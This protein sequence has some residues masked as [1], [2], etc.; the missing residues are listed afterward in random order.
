M[1]SFLGDSNFQAE[2]NSMKKALLIFF[3][4]LVIAIGIFAAVVA[5]QPDEFRVARSAEINAPPAAVFPHVNDFHNWEKW[6]PWVKLDPNAKYCYEGNPAGEGAIHRWA[7]NEDVGEGSMTI[8]ES[9]PNERVKIRLDFVKP[10]EDTAEV[11][12][13]FAPSSETTPDKTKVTWEMSGQNN[14]VGKAICL[15]MQMTK[16]MEKQFDEGLANMKSVVETEAG[17]ASK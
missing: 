11:V 1:L 5:M 13:T 16:E 3:G 15:A 17:T 4:T 10:M 2:D 9:K 14:F 7:G 12:F 6:S 8:L